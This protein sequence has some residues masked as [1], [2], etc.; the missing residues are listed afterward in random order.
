MSG[1]WS[2]SSW[3]RDFQTPEDHS[4]AGN[5]LGL[6][7]PRTWHWDPPG[8]WT[9]TLHPEL[10]RHMHVHW[11][12]KIHFGFNT[13]CWPICLQEGLMTETDSVRGHLSQIN[14]HQIWVK[15]ILISRLLR[16]TSLKR[17]RKRERTKQAYLLN[18][19]RNK[20]TNA[21]KFLLISLQ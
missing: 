16:N 1:H 18:H 2:L 20:F 7:V 15:K 6:Q 10:T 9:L 13:P 3:S 19:E 4:S 21:D 11:C 5:L 17:E 12:A 8:C 14:D